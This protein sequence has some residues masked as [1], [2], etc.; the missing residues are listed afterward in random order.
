MSRTDYAAGPQDDAPFTVLVF[1][2]AGDSRNLRK[3]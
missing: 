3:E 1:D 2:R